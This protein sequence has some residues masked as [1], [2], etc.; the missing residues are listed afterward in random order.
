MDFFVDTAVMLF[1]R[2]GNAARDHVDSLKG[3]QG[4]FVQSS[5]VVAAERSK[6]MRS[7]LYQGLLFR[8]VLAFAAGS[9]QEIRPQPT[10]FCADDK[11]YAWTCWASTRLTAVD[12]I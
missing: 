7:A 5:N 1:S 12:P 4:S 11:A 6:V 3:P 8:R 2:E 9:M 10:R